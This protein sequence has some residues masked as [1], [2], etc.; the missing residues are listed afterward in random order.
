MSLTGF[1]VCLVDPQET[2][3]QAILEVF[4]GSFIKRRPAHKISEELALIQRFNTITKLAYNSDH[5]SGST[6]GSTKVTQYPGTSIGTLSDQ[7][8]P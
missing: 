4:L 7:M 1:Q 5:R 3:D 8:T 2:Y 6:N